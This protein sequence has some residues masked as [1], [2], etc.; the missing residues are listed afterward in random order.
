MELSLNA[1]SFVEQHMYMCSPL[2]P[3]TFFFKG[4]SIGRVT[5]I[6]PLSAAR[7]WVS[8]LSFPSKSP[9]GDLVELRKE[10]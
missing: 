1:P 7:L 10:T 4:V 3:L 6:L 2:G 9:F 5:S 8:H